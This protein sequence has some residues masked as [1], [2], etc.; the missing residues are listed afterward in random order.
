MAS[1]LARCFR[2]IASSTGCSLS[3][4]A[5][6]KPTGSEGCLKSWWPPPT[7][8]MGATALPVSGNDC[9]ASDAASLASV[10]WAGAAASSSALTDSRWLLLSSVASCASAA[11]DSSPDLN[12]SRIA[13]SRSAAPLRN[14][15]AALGP[16]DDT[17]A[18]RRPGSSVRTCTS[19]TATREPSIGDCAP[20]TRTPRP[21]LSPGPSRAISRLLPEAPPVPAER[22]R[23]RASPWIRTCTSSAGLP[24]SSRVVPRP[25]RRAVPS[26]ARAT[27]CVLGSREKGNDAASCAARRLSCRASSKRSVRL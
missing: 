3:G 19:E 11:T 7:G 9:A 26:A 21:M 14:A 16:K 8:L 23:R 13:L 22:T 25:S 1:S 5:T 27:R 17:N 18:T 10:L 15:L 24:C 6:P 4:S 12:A 2:S 20:W